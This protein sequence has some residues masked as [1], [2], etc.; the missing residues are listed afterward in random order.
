MH[1]NTLLCTRP[2]TTTFD[3]DG[4]WMEISEMFVYKNGH[5][6]WQ[7]WWWWDV[8]CFHVLFWLQK[9]GTPMMFPCVCPYHFISFRSGNTHQNE[10]SVRSWNMIR[11]VRESWRHCTNFASRTRWWC[12]QGSRGMLRLKGKTITKIVAPSYDFI[13]D[14]FESF[15]RYLWYVL[16]FLISSS[17]FM[18]GRFESQASFEEFEQIC[19]GP[20]V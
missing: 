10:Y 4:D 2:V 19:D 12:S 11:P 13:D 1:Q 15:M 7:M 5:L 3:L 16:I 6:F 8:S 14:M 9:L 17:Y 20:R 18:Q